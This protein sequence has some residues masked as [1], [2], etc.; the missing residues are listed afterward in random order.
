VRTAW[1]VILAAGMIGAPVDLQATSPADTVPS[2]DEIRRL[3][4]PDGDRTAGLAALG[5]FAAS[6][7]PA[8]GTLWVQLLAAVERTDPG[9]APVLLEAVLQGEGGA[10]EEG[11]RSL[12]EAEEEAREEDRSAL[13]WM[14]ALV[15]EGADQAEAAR[16]RARLLERHPQALE[17]PEAAVRQARWLLASGE[18][19]EAAL[20]LLEGLV[21]DQ[22]DH[23]AA[24]EARALL[25]RWRDR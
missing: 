7:A 6:L 8:R 14:G 11:A 20:A 22:P 4:G 5:S 17:A 3:L 10:G 12:E 16:L 2:I 21:V 1:A 24:P 9:L 13:L 19:R 18:D 23:P 25:L 15:V